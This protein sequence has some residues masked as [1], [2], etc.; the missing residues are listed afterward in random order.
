MIAIE[1]QYEPHPDMNLNGNPLTE[2]ITVELDKEAFLRSIASKPN[3]QDNFWSLPPFYQMTQLR[4]LTD[5]HAPLPQTWNMYNKL[6][7]LILYS[8]TRRDPFSREMMMLRTSVAEQIRKGT[9]NQN[10]PLGLTTAPSVLVSGDS[11][12]GKTTTIRTVLRSIPQVIQHTSYNGKHFTTKQLAWVSFDLPPNGAPKAM[13]ANFFRSVDIALGTS[14]TDEWNSRSKDSVERHLSGMQQVALE[15]NLGLA[16]VDE[17]QFMLAYAKHPNSPSLQI[18]ESLFNKMGIPIVQSCTAEGLKLF[19]A[20]PD[21]DHRI[22]TDA[23]TVRRM[24]NDRAFPFSNHMGDSG[25]FR[26]LFSTLFPEGLIR[27]S[28]PNDLYAFRDK[29]YQLSCGLPA[30]MIRL[31]LLHHE[32]LVNLLGKPEIQHKGYHTYDVNLLERVYKNQFSLIDPALAQY[33][34]GDKG[35]YESSIRM[36]NQTTVYTNAERKEQEEKIVKNPP[37][38]I[39]T[40]GPENLM[41]GVQNKLTDDEFLSGFGGNVDV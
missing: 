22:G 39:K 28:N 15:H 41:L 16:H 5:I 37:Q 27:H 24:L 36:E 6:L 30:I 32:S 8:Y 25:Y 40:D 7:G 3:I 35:G 2:A 14:Y 17:L 34:R 38:V 26:E 33:R 10:L 21:G 19:D 20:L 11:G 23:T 4:Q 12:T 9:F 1:A 31:A 18:L 29:F 13:A